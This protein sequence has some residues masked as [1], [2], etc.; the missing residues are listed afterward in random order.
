MIAFFAIC[1]TSC[2]GDD[3]EIQTSSSDKEIDVI[4]KSLNGSYKGVYYISNTDNVWY[5]ETIS[6]HPYSETKS[7]MS[8]FDGSITAYGTAD[9]ADT[10]FLD[11]S[12]I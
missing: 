11:I 1:F 5:S 3:D 10:R 8:S 6:F 9:I 7:I 2:G 12:G 4:W